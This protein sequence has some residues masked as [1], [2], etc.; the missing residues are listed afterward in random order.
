MNIKKLFTTKLGFEIP[1]DLEQVHYMVFKNDQGLTNKL[2][3]KIYLYENSKQ[4]NTTFYLFDENLKPDEIKTVHKRI[5]NEN[6][7]DLFIFPK[8]D[9]IEIRYTK[10]APKK[11][12]IIIDSIPVNEEDNKLLEKISKTHFDSGIFW[13]TYKNALK[14]IQ[15]Q[16][17]TVDVKL[18]ETL[19]Y[20]R[21]KLEEIYSEIIPDVLKKK[22]IVQALIDRTLF[23]KFLEDRKIINSYFFEQL[24]K[25]NRFKEYKDILYNKNA[26]NINKFFDKINKTCNNVLF[27]EPIIDKKYLSSNVLDLL[28]HT[29]IQTDP[30]SDQLSLFPF[31]FDII[32]I[33]FISHIYEVFLEDKQKKEGIYYTPQ[34]LANLVLDS[35]IERN[36]FGKVLDPSCGSGI[37]L[38]L[39]FRRMLKAKKLNFSNIN[40]TSELIKK[41]NEFLKSNIFGIE[42]DPTARRLTIFSLYLEMFN[43]IES[44]KIK[45]LIRN[46][47]INPEF[48]LFPEHFNENILRGNAV[49]KDKKK[50]P[51]N[52]KKF[53]YIIGNPP[54]KLIDEN[55]DRE[56]NEYWI[57]NQQNL[58]GKK[59]LSQCFLIEIKNWAKKDTNYGFV[60]NSSN[61]YNE[62]HIKFQDF[63]LNN[64]EIEKFYLKVQKKMHQL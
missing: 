52:N 31:E 5:W 40:D 23:I 45:E 60:V 29:I 6:K 18:I 64:Y 30:N 47:I 36:R 53:D 50:K 13:F 32:P 2:S 55:E 39:A 16:R 11:N 12:P 27:E 1:N 41:R 19:K 15:K 59:Q 62:T 38:V 25:D 17:Q 24:F 4:A 21:K 8:N 51:F 7:A 56:E 57:A 49:V 20:L 14:R 37:F 42:K 33:E 46:N 35:V 9:Q 63:F 34:G 26:D 61:F 22:N 48:K 43:N 10:T 54:W 28:Y 44:E 3:D 58:G